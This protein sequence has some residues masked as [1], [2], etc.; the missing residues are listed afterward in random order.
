LGKGGIL[1]IFVDEFC[2][3]SSMTVPR[4]TPL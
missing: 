2:M 3:A 4:P 1:F